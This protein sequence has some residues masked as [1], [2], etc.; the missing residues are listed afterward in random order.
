MHLLNDKELNPEKMTQS[1]IQITDMLV[2]YHAVTARILNVN[3]SGIGDLFSA[4]RN[5]VP[6]TTEWLRAGLFVQFYNLLFNTFSG[7]SVAMCHWLWAQNKTLG[8]T[9]RLAIVDE[10]A[11]EQVISL[12]RDESNLINR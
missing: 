9:P 7:D 8:N 4:R 1:V 5:L 2:P 12:L 6:N 3:C 11:I 10:N